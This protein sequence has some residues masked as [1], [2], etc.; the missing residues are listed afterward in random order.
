MPQSKHRRRHGGGDGGRGPVRTQSPAQPRK[1]KT[2]YLYVAVSAVIAVLVIAGFVLPQVLS[3]GSV[4]G[5]STGSSD[6]YVPGV[7]EQQT[8][9]STTNHLP[10]GQTVTYNT[11]PPTSGD[12]WAR[13]ADCGFYETGM[14]DERTT[15]NLEH[16][17]IVV[18][19]HLTAPEEVTQLRDV[20][21]GIGLANV[22]SITRFYDKIPEGTVAVA[23]WGVLDTMEGI[24]G[25]RIK[26]FIETYA[27]NLGP[28][29]VRC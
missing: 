15:H 3:L 1:R 19:Y 22:W 25:D 14:P 17:N 5:T 20:I 2:N 9:M 21:D 26:R 27:G 10:E 11:I 29:R 8:I 16:G 4:G 6:Q 18:S 7:G 23:T 12:H 13:W 28:E 24:D